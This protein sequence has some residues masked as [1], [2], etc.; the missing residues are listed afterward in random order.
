MEQNDEQYFDHQDWKQIVIN[1]KSKRSK[2]EKQTNKNQEYNKIKKLENKAETDNLQHNIYP[3]E[4]RKHLVLNRTRTL[5]MTQKQLA[6]RLNMPE[7]TI[8][9]IESGAA[10]YNASHYNKIKRLLKI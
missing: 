8:K 1:N 4:F 5:N 10:I 3:V 2:K 9:D 7:K 6:N